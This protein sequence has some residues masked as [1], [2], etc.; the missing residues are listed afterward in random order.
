MPIGGLSR[1]ETYCHMITIVSGLPRSGTSLAMQMLRAAGQPVYFNREPNMDKNNPRGYFEWENAREL[2]QGEKCDDLFRSVDGKIVK[3]F[4]QLFPCLSPRFE[5]RFIYIDRPIP[6]VMKSQKA[7]MR[8]EGKPEGLIKQSFLEKLRFHSMIYLS[9]F[10]H[11]VITHSS[12][13]TGLASKEIC[14]FLGLDYV[15]EAMM[16]CVDPSMR[17]HKP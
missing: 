5:Y 15:S 1:E 10:S 4:P 8:S 17:H 13:Y 7:M 6:E 14:N 11:R 12:L 3:I 16:D 9:Y 2:W